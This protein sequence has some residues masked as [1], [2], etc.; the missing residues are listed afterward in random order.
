MGD[1]SEPLHINVNFLIIYQAD[2]TLIASYKII[3]GIC[4]AFYLIL[5]L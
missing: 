2:T 4:S 3:A 5:L 1:T